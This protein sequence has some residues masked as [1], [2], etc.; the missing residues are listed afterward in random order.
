[1]NDFKIG[2]NVEEQTAEVVGKRIKNKRK[3]AIIV[4]VVVSLLIGIFTF[5]ISNAIFN[6]KEAPVEVNTSVSLTD[7]NVQILYQYVTYGASGVRGNKFVKND[8]VT[9]DSF[10]SQEKF[11]YALQF[12]DAEDFEFTGEVNQ[13]KNK[14][15]LIS[16]KKIKKYMQQFFGPRVSYTNNIEISHP[17]SF[18][19]NQMNV[20][21]MVYSDDQDGFKTTFAKLEEKKSKEELNSDVVG[22]LISAK[23]D[24]SGK[25]IL[26]EKVVFTSIKKNADGMYDI[27]IYKD[28]NQ[29]ILLDKKTVASIDKNYVDLSK[30]SNTTTVEYTFALNGSVYYFESSTLKKLV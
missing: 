12:A 11:Y 1:M 23:T 8:N 28:F 9:L 26:D 14:V 13:D 25:M 10:S 17:F 19:I 27:E 16:N 18:R 2:D 15:Y 5:V 7:E 24:S 4:V 22:E 3:I 20:G 6:K 29:E 30:F 21:D